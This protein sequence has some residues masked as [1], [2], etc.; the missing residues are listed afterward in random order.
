MGNGWASAEGG[1]RERDR[2][3]FLSRSLTGS[4]R[5]QNHGAP[6]SLYTHEATD[7]VEMREYKTHPYLRAR[8]F[9]AS[10]DL[11]TI[12]ADRDARDVTMRPSG[13]SCGRKLYIVEEAL[14]ERARE[15]EQERE[16]KTR[17]S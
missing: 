17:G 10:R 6:L 3:V 12:A 11:C 7:N 4:T 8:G 14:L 9:C 2:D 15:G 13:L 16:E 1:E 5:T